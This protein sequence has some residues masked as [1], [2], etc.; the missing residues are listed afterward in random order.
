M[1]RKNGRRQ[2][3]PLTAR[4]LGYHLDH[5][6]ISELYEQSGLTVRQVARILRSGYRGTLAR[7]RFAG[8]AP[9]RRGGR[10]A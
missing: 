4:K 2:Y 3:H 5:M 8:V 10:W 1:M 7:M 9:R 6:L